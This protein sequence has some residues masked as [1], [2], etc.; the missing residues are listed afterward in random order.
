MDIWNKEKEKDGII[1]KTINLH[2]LIKR[3]GIIFDID[4]I[5]IMK[6]AL[7]SLIDELEETHS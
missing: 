4:D 2:R 6:L 7:A 5:E 1:I 3:L